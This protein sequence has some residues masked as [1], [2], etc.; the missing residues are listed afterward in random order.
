MI[1]AAL[2]P[3]YYAAMYRRRAM[4]PAKDY[5]RYCRVATVE[6]DIKR[7]LDKGVDIT[8]IP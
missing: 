1:P 4:N 7:I 5:E 3:T 6:N 2:V 8:A